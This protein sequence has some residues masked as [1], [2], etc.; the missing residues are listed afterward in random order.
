MFTGFRCYAPM[1]RNQV[2]NSPIQ[3][4]A[5]HCL[6]YTFINVTNELEKN[7]MDT[8]LIGE[9]HDAIIPDINPDEEKQFDNIIWYYGTRKIREDWDWVI[10]PLKIEKSISNVDESWTKVSEVGLLNAQNIHHYL[11]QYSIY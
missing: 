7:K 4:A 6:L 8:R 1:S 3:G 2:L 5:F 9:I 10:V 11:L